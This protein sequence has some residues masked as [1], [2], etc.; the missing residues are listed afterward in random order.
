[1]PRRKE[2]ARSEPEITGLTQLLKEY[3]PCNCGACS[4]I[5][6]PNCCWACQSEVV[7]YPVRGGLCHR[8]RRAG[9][10][11]VPG[12]QRLSVQNRAQ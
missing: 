5:P 9:F 11:E 3:A 2:N 6:N 4:G 8:C 1:M 7:L 12:V 10:L